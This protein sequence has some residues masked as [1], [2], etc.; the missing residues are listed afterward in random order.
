MNKKRPKSANRQGFIQEKYP[1][2]SFQENS[3]SRNP[4]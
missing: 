4:L 2:A 3:E 1:G